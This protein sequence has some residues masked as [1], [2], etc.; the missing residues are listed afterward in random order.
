VLQLH[1][2][3]RQLHDYER[4]YCMDVKSGNHEWAR[5]AAGCLQFRTTPV[6]TSHTRISAAMSSLICPEVNVG[7]T[8]D[9]ESAG[10][11]A[12]VA[13]RAVITGDATESTSVADL[14]HICSIT[15]PSVCAVWLSSKGLDCATQSWEATLWAKRASRADVW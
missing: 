11:Q 10:L 2:A 4:S 6:V 3:A 15:E 12:Q 14:S 5:D 1:R 13:H 7:L 9:L 8:P